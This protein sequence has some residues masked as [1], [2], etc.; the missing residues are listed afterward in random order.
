MFIEWCGSW[1]R[2]SSIVEMMMLSTLV[3]RE[4]VTF[5]RQLC[6]FRFKNTG[7]AVGA[8]GTAGSVNRT[9]TDWIT[10]GGIVGLTVGVCC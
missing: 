4:A 7:K 2:V 9:S 3:A 10:G 6:P 1:G 8:I 5:S